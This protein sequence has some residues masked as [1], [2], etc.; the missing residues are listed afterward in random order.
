MKNRPTYQRI[1]GVAAVETAL[2]IPIL[3]NAMMGTLEIC[4]AIY[5]KES[6]AVCAFEGARVG[7]RRYATADDVTAR[8]QEAL[9]DRKVVIPNEGG[10]GVRVLPPDFS[11]LS[12]LDP[13]TIEI[14]AP[15]AGNSIFVF[16][17]L[18]N[19]NITA[20]VTMVRE[21]DE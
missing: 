1:K 16:D 20:S 21:F 10:F 18:F 3:L 6:I 11:N 12:A 5:L 2:C 7:I 9:D 13:I 19:R 4:S 8:V 17:T 14:I 15:T